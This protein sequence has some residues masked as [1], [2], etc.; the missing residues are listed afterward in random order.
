MKIVDFKEAQNLL[1]LIQLSKRMLKELEDTP[2]D[3][4][5]SAKQLRQMYSDRQAEWEKEFEEL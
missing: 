4:M 5:V 2:D 1:P 3:E